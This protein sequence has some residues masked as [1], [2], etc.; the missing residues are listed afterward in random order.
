MGNAVKI[1]LDSRVDRARVMGALDASLPYEVD[2]VVEYQL[3]GG[4]MALDLGTLD[5]ADLE[6]FLVV[7]DRCSYAAEAGAYVWKVEYKAG[8]PKEFSLLGSYVRDAAGTD[9]SLKVIPNGTPLKVRF[10]VA[11]FSVNNFREI[12]LWY[13]TGFNPAD[14]ALLAEIGIEL[15]GTGDVFAVVNGVE[16]KVSFSRPGGVGD[17]YLIDFL[18]G[19]DVF[20]V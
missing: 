9:G 8:S 16:F 15:K 3:G 17:L 12:D 10:E 5:G 13:G 6:A 19:G 11:G 4:E 7:I 18:E 20:G 2:L 14:V 1:V